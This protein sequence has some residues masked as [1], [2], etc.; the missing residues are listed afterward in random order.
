MNKVGRIAFKTILWIIGTII[1]LILLI[2]ILIRIPAVQNFAVQQVV[3]FLEKKIKTPVKIEKVSLDLPKL[4]VLEGVYFEDQKQ[5]TLLAGDQL[6]VDISLLKLLKN[7]VEI[8]E[9]DLK[10]ITTKIDRTLPDSS[11]NFDYIIRAFVSEEK[12]EPKPEDTTSTME[13]SIDK[14]NLD[15]IRFVYKD[16]VIGTSA[17]FNLG[18]LDTRIKTFDLNNMRFEIPKVNVKGINTT[19]KQ[20]AVVDTSDLPSTKDIGIEE[21]TGA[22]SAM[23]DLQL[24]G[25][26]IEDVKAQY[27]DEISALNAS[28]L[29][30]RL[31]VDFNN[32]NLKGETIDIK[33]ILL[34]E[35][36]TEVAFGKVKQPS[37][38]KEPKSVDSA[39]SQPIN[40]KV[41]IGDVQL[42]KSQ[43][44]YF[45][46]NQPRIAKGMDY[47]N[48]DMTTVDAKMSDF[49][50]SIDSISGTLKQLN[51]KDRS[52]F[53]INKAE[54]DFVY[55]EKG[56]SAQNLYIET[57]NTLIR[58]YAKVSYPSLEQITERI[59]EIQVD[60]NI[61]KSK[62]GM[63]DVLLLVPDLD[64]MEVMKPL[65]THTFFIDGQVKGRVDDL[66]ISNIVFSTLDRTRLQASA[67]LK[68]LPDVDKFY[69]DL[70]L[71]NLETGKRD[72]DRLIAKSM[73]P[74]S[75]ELPQ[76][77][78]LNGLFKGGL[79]QF[80]TNMHLRSS[81]GSADLRANY[82]AGR[83][84]TYDADMAIRDINVGHLMKMDSTLGKISFAAQI[85]GK[86]LDPSKLVADAKAKL[87]SA[88]AMGYTYTNINL[89]AKA[90]SGDVEASLT[91][92]DPNISLNGQIAAKLS[93]RHPKFTLNLLVDSINTKNLKLTNDN[94]RFHGNFV[95]DFDS[96]DPDY[97]NGK[98]DLTKAIIAYNNDRYVLDTISV[99]AQAD[100]NQNLIQLRSEFLT[101]HMIG[102][103]KLSTLSYAFQ[104]VLN[105]YY[106]PNP[107]IDKKTG[108]PD[109][110]PAYSPTQIEFGAT[111]RRSPLIIRVMPEL[112]EMQPIT[113]DGNFNSETKSINVKGVAPKA[114][115][116]GTDIQNVS[117]DINT[118]DS[119]LY[120]AALVNSI[121]VSSIEIINTLLSGTVK[122]S[123]IDA[124]LWIKDKKGKEQYHL[125]ANL[126]ARAEDFRFSLKEDGL[127]L[128]YDK[129]SVNPQNV[130]SFGSKGLLASHFDL[131]QSGQEMSIASQDSVPNSPLAVDFKNFRIETFANMVESA[132]L[133]VGGGI[134]GNA[135]V[136]RLDGYPVFTSDITINDFYFGQDTIG[137]IGLQVNNAKENTYNANITVQGQ[138]NDIQLSGD[139]ITPLDAEST[140]DFDLLVNNLN[141]STLE[142]FSFGNLRRTSGGI[143]GK[144]DLTGSL[145]APVINGDLIFNQAKMNISMLNATFTMDQ[146]RI[147]FNNRG[148]G[149]KQFTLTD[150]IGNKAIING[151]IRTK[152]YTEFVLGMDVKANDF[153]VLNST[154]VD[155]NLFYGKLNIDT[156]LR[157][158]GAAMSPSLNGTLRVN[159]NTDMTLTMPETDPGLVEREG[160]VEFTS[161]SPRDSAEILAVYDTTET[162][163][164]TIMGM[165]IS[166]NIDVDKDAAFTV[167]VDPGTG[168]KLFVKGQA[169]LNFGINPG[170]DMTLAGTYEV[171][172]GN[173]SLSFNMIKR[174]FDFKKGSTITWGGDVMDADLNMTAIYTL[175][176]Q[177]IDLVQVSGT[178]ANY[179]R[180]R[181]PFNVNLHI[182][183]KML[184]PEISFGIDLGT[185]G[186][187]NT[188]SQ[189]VTQ[190]VE[191]KL[192][193]LRD[194]PSEMNKQTFALIV[195]GRFIAENPFSSAGG[196]STETMVRSSVS[197]LL[198][199]QLNKLAGDLIAGVEL[200]FDLQSTADDYSTG[201]AQTRTDLNV[202]VSKRMLDDRLKVTVGS[203]F[204][205]EGGGQPGQ[206]ATNI[207][208]D[209][210]IEYQLS[211]DG[212]YIARVYRKNQYQVTL[213][214]QFIETGLG[215][216]INMNYDEFKELFMN[217]KRR[218]ELNDKRAEEMKEHL[219]QNGE[220]EEDEEGLDS[221]ER[222]KD[223]QNRGN[224]QFK[225]TPGE[226]KQNPSPAERSENVNKA[227]RNEDEV[228]EQK[229]E[230]SNDE[231]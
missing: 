89:A 151:N 54:A 218:Q 183:G 135:L 74:D 18:H 60:A 148:I 128:N 20:W 105:T 140:M 201:Q 118:L 165:N 28:I 45:D 34:D 145:D 158:R 121:K 156:D 92:E 167:I 100:T 82:A 62:L 108:L 116:A 69:M 152:T 25:L 119:T 79:N 98:L 206:K 163:A 181:L 46:A 67:H 120:Y 31:L 180:Q 208:G 136:D 193:Q 8:N 37:I 101:A 143:S 80:T 219:E 59:G 88:E 40:W 1:G 179:Y 139:Y 146:Q 178:E 171:E 15:R 147:N 33:R 129:W 141:M 19:I 215:F 231:G 130:I 75:I 10:G 230:K 228:T 13:F 49:F 26:H 85:K 125:G 166:L 123:S 115:Y 61:E 83:D 195:L 162:K 211:R 47:G 87:I 38:T 132:S 43:V 44:S 191:A 96:A 150:S 84:T 58:N 32:I 86:G 138:G 169:L 223:Q 220:E 76:Q 4:L 173:Y 134:N 161:L 122:N 188:V 190:T 68:G 42:N 55:T 81:I 11:F 12:E 77:L 50:F 202:G 210:S 70:Q 2:F 23:P 174:R 16:D 229:P 153:Q 160:I 99:I 137:N 72:L 224:R 109:T 155:N 36:D 182:G 197:S 113:L 187:A 52:G 41:N 154:E 133:D 149:F 3:S 227:Y 95:A 102:N 97:L 64:T 117:F 185:G 90:N 91:S 14:I 126:L 21:A 168:D 24:G 5:D 157:I 142:T 30:K 170:G 192:A 198:T 104:D 71:K 226:K 63:K 175:Q 114:V 107:T 27:I 209:I 199:S 225:E 7:K 51:F 189:T 176:A 205:L 6:K 177:P 93:E 103:Y 221:L 216:I 159:E 131:N 112:T 48:L 57:P 124:G 184:K 203:N 9:I 196:S 172:E 65:I 164:N 106:N 66:R 127:M 213:Q 110:I 204:E 200:N 56:A 111:F 212:R 144:L 194:N 53:I 214:G 73:L 222:R 35:N 17:D 186:N 94:I 78:K 39:D 29:F 207:A 217:A 22:E